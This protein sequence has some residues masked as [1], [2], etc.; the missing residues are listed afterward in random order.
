MAGY[1]HFFLTLGPAVSHRLVAAI[2]F[3][4]GGTLIAARLFGSQVGFFVGRL[5]LK[6]A[7]RFVD[8]VVRLVVGPIAVEVG[9]RHQRAWSTR[10]RRLVFMAGLRRT[11]LQHSAFLLAP[12]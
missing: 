6:L 12:A 11:G 9:R 5:G 4:F 1:R 2:G 8:L 7:F 10:H 3:R